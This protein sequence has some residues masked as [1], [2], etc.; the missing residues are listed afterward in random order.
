MSGSHV[1]RLLAALCLCL[2]LAACASEPFKPCEVSVVGVRPGKDMAAQ[3]LSSLLGAGQ[4]GQGGPEFVV[5]LKVTNPNNRE[6]VLRGLSGVVSGPGGELGAF[7]LS[8]EKP[9][10]LPAHGSTVVD[11]LAEPGAGFLKGALPLLLSPSSRGQLKATGHAD[12][13]SWLGVRR[14]E[15]KDV[16]LGGGS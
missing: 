1:R 16:R 2:L 13:D 15:F 9:T 14:V 12:V 10:P 4:A 5:S 3:L 11:I 8:E 7:R 6:V